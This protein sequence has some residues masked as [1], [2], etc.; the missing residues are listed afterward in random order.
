MRVHVF[1]LVAISISTATAQADEYYPVD[2]AQPVKACFNPCHDMCFDSCASRW[3]V[4]YDQLF[5]KFH[6]DGGVGVPSQGIVGEFDADA[7][8]RITVGRSFANGMY[9]EFR[10]FDYD[11]TTDDLQISIGQQPLPV[12]G[13]LSADLYSV[14]LV[15]GCRMN[16]QCGISAMVEGGV[17]YYEF[18]EGV[19][20]PTFDA[21]VSNRGI[22]VLIG[23]EVTKTFCS[24]F[25]LYVNAK[26]GTMTGDG[27]QTLFGT[28]AELSDANVT[29]LEYGAGLGY[30]RQLRNDWLLTARVGAEY[31]NYFSAGRDFTVFNPVTNDIGLSGLALRIGVAR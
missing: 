13:Q 31:I 22:G 1:L 19:T 3:Y 27:D 6:K 9:A 8:Y 10:W 2:D 7:A 26:A 28:T 23:G 29:T 30:T 18:E 14:D 16:M 24:N 17:R 12:P 20:T 5:L 21:N 11:A 25:S 4:N 15:V